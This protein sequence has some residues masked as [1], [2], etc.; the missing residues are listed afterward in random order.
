MIRELLGLRR[1]VPQILQ[2]ERAECGLAC[3][4]MVAAYHG[5][6]VD[7][8]T[9]RQRFAFSALGATLRE[10]VDAA[11]RLR[12]SARAIKAP[13]AALPRMA[14][15]LVLHW[16][17]NHF[18]VLVA[19][20]GD[21][22]LVIHDPATGRR[23]L[24][25]DQ[26]SEHYTGVAVE[27]AP[28]SDFLRKRERTALT[29]RQLLRGALHGGQPLRH[30]LVFALVTQ[31]L[32][33][34]VPLAGQFLV[35]SVVPSGSMV[36]IDLLGLAL[37]LVVGSVFVG[38]MA[39]GL[40]FVFLGGAVH[41][42]LARN[43][44]RHLMDLPLSF[45][46]RRQA[47][48]LVARFDSL[49][50]IQR[51]LSVSFVEAIVDGFS[52]VLALAA[53][54]VYSP[55]LA[56]LG[57]GCMSLYALTRWSLQHR[58][59]RLSEEQIVKGAGVQ[60]SFIESM[61]GIESIKA[62]NGQNLRNATW[63]ALLSA[64]FNA[65]NRLQA[66][67]AFFS[68]CAAALQLF[69]FGLCLWYG[70]RRAVTG[71]ISLGV[72][73]ACVSLLQLFSIRFVALVDKLADFGMLSIHR[74]RLSDVYAVEP[75]QAMQGSG[76]LSRAEIAGRIEL[77]DVSFRYDENRPWVLRGA[78]LTV[79]AGEFVA[80]TGQSGE[81]KST[82]LRIMLGLLDP[83]QGQLL[84]D[85]AELRAL[86]KERYRDSVGVVLQDDTLFSGSILENI[87]TFDPM[88]DMELVEQCARMAGIHETIARF[89]MGYRTL[90]GDMGSLLSG[91]QQQ[92]IFLARALY[93]KPRVLFLDE[94]T[95]H[96]DVARER[97][98]NHEIS[99]IGITRIVI[100]HRLETIQAASRVIRMIDGQLVESDRMLH[101]VNA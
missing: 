52:M 9:M 90:V 80:I 58:Y 41:L 100:A 72:L 101:T 82:L 44:F 62:H 59:V 75:E 61:R 77:C 2:A 53:V 56:A 17:F 28:M 87:C 32:A 93:R 8:P 27:F 88:P 73:M 57:T 26:A 89:P 92:R 83:Q 64:W 10:L 39:R 71:E 55:A 23:T 79:E 45:F 81:G 12:L 70:G 14:L 4:T 63:G 35:D 42:H 13:L 40:T 46:Q 95:S 69:G 98:I 11:G 24:S 86:G 18:V 84:V 38:H 22:S 1:S 5:Y 54:S 67:V 91:G 36:D 31:L 74:A 65:T 20:R 94:A 15:P 33:L 48:D 51:I 96:L 78:S 30:G 34:S 66:Q 19:T 37:L 76:V 43:L 21:G 85:G 16:D 60:T 49:R 25:P 47:S 3:L 6:D 29:F 68:A 99:K 97:E 50:V 7:L